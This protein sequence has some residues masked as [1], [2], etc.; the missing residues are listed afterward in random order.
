MLP[1]QLVKKQNY[2]LKM[3]ANSWHLRIWFPWLSR[4]LNSAWQMSQMYFTFEWRSL[5]LV[6]LFLWVNVLGQSGHLNPIWPVWCSDKIRA[7]LKRLP[8]SEHKN[9]ERKDLDKFHGIKFED[10][11]SYVCHLNDWCDAVANVAFSKIVL[12]RFRKWMVSPSRLFVSI[13]ESK[14][15]VH[16]NDT[17]IIVSFRSYASISD[18][19]K[20]FFHH[21]RIPNVRSTWSLLRMLSNNIHI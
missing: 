19:C 20:V 11:D 2:F 13:F 6:K 16:S 12:H 14:S 8:H 3:Q 5:W 10:K 9:A 7:V 1:Y 15:Y 17:P 18:I 4:V 21:G